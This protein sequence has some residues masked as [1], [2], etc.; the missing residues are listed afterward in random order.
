MPQNYLFRHLKNYDYDSF[1]KEE[2][3]RR[4]AL[5]Y[6]PYARLLLM[7]LIS[8]RD[9]A[10]KLS[11]LIHEMTPP[12]SKN[13]KGGHGTEKRDNDLKDVEILGPFTTRNRKGKEEVNLLLKSP[14]RA[15]LHETAKTFIEAFKKLK[16]VRIKVDVDPIVI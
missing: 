12:P 13:C 7:K 10:P 1:F 8:E 9:I 2:L 11:E 4:K 6:P 14:V 16:D 3:G 5:A 15:N